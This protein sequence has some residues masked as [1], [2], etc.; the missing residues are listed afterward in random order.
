MSYRLSGRLVGL[1]CDDCSEPLRGGTLR[2]VRVDDL[3]QGSRVSHAAA[4]DPKST[5]AVL[6]TEQ[7]DERSGRVIA[8]TVLA[9]DGSFTV[10]LGGSYAGEAFEVDLYCGT[11]TGHPVPPRPLQVALTTLAPQWRASGTDAAKEFVAAWEYEIP[12][13]FWCAIRGLLGWWTIC[14][15][16]TVCGTDVPV[17]G[18]TVSAFDVDWLQ[19]DALGSSVT[20]ASGHFRVDYTTAQF[21][22][23]PLS[24]WINFELVPG[25]DVYFRITGLGGTL[26]AEPR[27]RGRAADRQ[28]IGPCFCVHLCVDEQPPVD[29]AY[30]WFDHVGGYKLLTDIDSGPA[31]SGRTTGNRAFYAGLRLNGVLGRTLGGQPLQYRFETSTTGTDPVRQ[32]QMT[33]MQIGTME[34]FVFPGPAETKRVVVLGVN[35]PDEIA[36]TPDADGWITVPQDN[37]LLTGTFVPN[38]NLLGLASATL[39]SQTHDLSAVTAGHSTVPAGLATDQLVTLRMVI[40]PAVASPPPAV[41]AG[42]CDRLALANTIYNQVEKNGSWVPGRYDGYLGALSIDVEELIGHGCAKITTAL[43]VLYTAA[44]P[45]LGSVSLTVT[46]PGGPYHYVLPAATPDFF[47]SVTALLDHLGNPVAIASLPPCGY[48]LSA[49]AGLLLTTG[50]SEPLPENDFL[51]FTKQ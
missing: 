29:D 47:G 33:A 28:N 41:Q 34:K 24:P 43:T 44:H 13:R 16:V 32:A 4:A 48:Q 12:A 5:V 42:I 9:D 22:R 26:L 40:R 50:D 7:A 11:L 20:D 10:V 49:S 1:L 19:D 39:S 6:T 51:V 36:V 31:G 27:S 25:P 38:N 8:E 15:Q 3:T 14:G 18:V 46:G 17:S 37:N 23:T 35:G 21:T 45:N 30:P 2:L